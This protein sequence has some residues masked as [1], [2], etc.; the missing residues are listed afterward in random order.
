MVLALV[1]ALVSAFNNPP[2]TPRLSQFPLLK[3][4]FLNTSPVDGK[5]IF[6]VAFYRK[7]ENEEEPEEDEEVGQ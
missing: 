2:L 6:C 1:S 7:L 5:K 3:V 4:S